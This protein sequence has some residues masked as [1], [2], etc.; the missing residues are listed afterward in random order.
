MPTKRAAIVLALIFAFSAFAKVRPWSITPSKGPTTGGTT[1][2]IKGAFGS[3]PYGVIFG[4]VWAE[5]A[6]RVDDDTIVTV[7]PPHLA[8]RVEVTVFEGDIYLS[9]PL[10][11]TYEGPVPVESFARV[12]L[13]V[14]IPPAHGAGGAQWWTD[15]TLVAK[16]GREATVH[17]LVQDCVVLCVEPP[18]SPITIAELRPLHELNLQPNGTPGRFF[19]VLKDELR[20][21]SAHLRAFDVSREATNYGTELP[22]VNF[23]TESDSVITLASVPTDPRFRNLLRVYSDLAIDVTIKA[24]DVEETLHLE[25]TTDNH[26][27][28]YGAW[29]NFPSGVGPITVTVTAHPPIGDPPLPGGKIWAFATV[30][31]ND[32]QAITTVTPQP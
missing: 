17:G 6:I 13:P 24:G 27:P 12:L 7:T 1:V 23:D 26:A 18:G 28:A 15:L 21:F 2:T 20:N 29:A 30:T 9:T 8:G 4:G 16:P 32:T 22:V 19:Y 31:N 10:T 25:G 11:Y 3:W 14:F 5:S